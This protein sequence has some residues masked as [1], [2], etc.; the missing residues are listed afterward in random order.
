MKKYNIFKSIIKDIFTNGITL[1]I[2]ILLG[3]LIIAL[4]VYNI[5]DSIFV[6]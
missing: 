6:F 5:L 1:N 2:I 3:I 4:G